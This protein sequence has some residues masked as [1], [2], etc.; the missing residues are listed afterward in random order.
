M[1]INKI[2]LAVA[3]VFIGSTVSACSTSTTQSAHNLSVAASGAN[4]PMGSDG[5]MSGSRDGSATGSFTVNEKLKNICYSIM[6]KHLTGIT[7]A[8]IQV[9]ASEKD[10][11]VFDISKMNMMNESCMNVEPNVLKD[12]LAQPGKY[13]L[14]VHTGAY[15]EGAVMGSLK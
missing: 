3:I 1:K 10:V 4:M 13:S 7:E 5:M 14:M 11:V 2:V 15:P 6:T 8:H 9:T 12:M